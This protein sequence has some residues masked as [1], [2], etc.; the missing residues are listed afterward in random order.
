VNKIEGNKTKVASLFDWY[1]KDF[2]KGNNTVPKFFNKY[3]NTQMNEN[4]EITYMDYDW[5]LNGD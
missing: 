5:S 1:G 3:S 2:K 4:A